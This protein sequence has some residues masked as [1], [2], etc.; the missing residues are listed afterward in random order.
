MSRKR[1]KRRKKR[2]PSEKLMPPQEKI[3]TW[4]LPTVL[5]LIVTV[6]GA[7]GVV[8]LRPQMNA[9]PQP[10]RATNQP[11]SAPFEITNTGYLGFHV[12]N[13]VVI[14]PIVE[15]EGVNFHNAMIGNVD[16]DN[17]DLNRGATK[18]IFPYFAN[19]RPKKAT[20]V[21][22][23]DYK[24]FCVK[25]RWL[26]K[27]DGTYIDNWQWSKQPIRAEDEEG[28]NRTVNDALSKH[29]QPSQHP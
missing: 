26:F 10:E 6:V 23:V 9:S 21:I 18:T 13:V 25:Q 2:K 14:F 17:F 4:T 22:A 7:L 28:L 8:E 3:R 27:F 12:E 29:Q 1:K 11:F 15:Y 19:G 16:W 5:G 24:Y 20:I